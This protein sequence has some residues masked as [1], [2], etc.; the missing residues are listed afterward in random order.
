[1]RVAL[2]N[3]GTI[4]NI[5][6]ADDAESLP[7]GLAEHTRPIRPDTWAEPDNPDDPEAAPTL[8]EAGDRVWIGDPW[9]PE[10][11][12]HLHT[13]DGQEGA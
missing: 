1:M 2:I 5:I 11:D 4:T 12:D 3:N 13:D 8:I 9:W 6:E 10:T 7:E